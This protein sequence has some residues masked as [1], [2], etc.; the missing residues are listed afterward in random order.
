MN[1]SLTALFAAFEAVLVGAIGVGIVLAPL[2]VLWGVQYGFALDWTVFWRAS[3]DAWLLGHGVD[4][5]VA[6][7]PVTAASLPLPGVDAP[8]TVTIAAL[9]FALL[10]LLLA[11]RA[12]KRVAET[13][14]HWIGYSSALA[15][16]GLVSF[17]VASSAHYPSA[18]PSLF[19]GTV[20]P[21]LVFAIGL[22]IGRLR[23]HKDPTDDRGSSLRDWVNDWSAS[24]R[25]VVFFALRGGAAVAFVVIAVA[26]FA[27]ALLLAVNY[28][29]IIRLYEGLHTE[30]LGGIALTIGELAFLPNVV[31]WAASWFVGPGFALGAGSAVSPL[32]TSLG[33]IPAVPLLGALPTGAYDYGF[34]GLLVPVVFAFLVAVFARA[35]VSAFLGDGTVMV[36]RGRRWALLLGASGGMGVVAGSVLGVLAW[37]SAGAAGPGRLAEVGPNP[38]W[39]AGLAFLEVGI[40]A[41]LGLLAGRGAAAGG[42]G[43]S[44]DTSVAPGRGSD[45]VDSP[46]RAASRG[47]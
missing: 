19:Q 28:A 41:L 42:A 13:H 18:H 6:L 26:G 21:T 16:F 44:G 25:S 40:G 1:R 31:I 9:G 10:T 32:G 17:G 7:D 45:A 3:A 39:V 43:A 2:T 24:T 5:T 22:L 29:T 12:G 15:A 38:W 23:A 33:P 46:V 30:V 36:T 34:A 47:H 27:V 8:F 4:L 35:S 20:L 14:F 37:A 11:V